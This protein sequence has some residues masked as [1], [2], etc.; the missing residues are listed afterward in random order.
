MRLAD[1][2]ALPTRY[3]QTTRIIWCVARPRAAAIDGVSCA[4]SV[5]CL[6]DAIQTIC[7]TYLD[8]VSHPAVQEGICG[9]MLQA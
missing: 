8:N 4:I 6:R 5:H 2:C 9:H 3:I 1:N 7:S